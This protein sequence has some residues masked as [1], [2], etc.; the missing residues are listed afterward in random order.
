MAAHMISGQVWLSQAECGRFSS[1]QVLGVSSD[2]VAV[3]PL[4]SRQVRSGQANSGKVVS[5]Q[6]RSPD[7]VWCGHAR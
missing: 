5:G 1:G 2:E 3:G 6:V 4:R 7:Q